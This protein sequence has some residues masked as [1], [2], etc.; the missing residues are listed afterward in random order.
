MAR[1]F[2]LAGAVIVRN[3]MSKQTD[4]ASVSK[5]LHESFERN[6][7]RACK[8]RLIFLSKVECNISEILANEGLF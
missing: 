8:A 4:M 2:S 1:L 5:I 7:S 3:I 6:I